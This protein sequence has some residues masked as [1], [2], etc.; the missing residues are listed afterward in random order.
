VA[1]VEYES[2]QHVAHITLNSPHNRN[3]LSPS[4]IA[5]LSTA[6]TRASEN[7]DLKVVLLDAAPPVFCA[8]ID[9]VA[10]DSGDALSLA[11]ALTKVQR[12]LVAHPLPVVAQVAGPVRAG[13]VGLLAPVDVVLASQEANFS[14]GEVRLGLTAGVIAV[15]LQHRMAPRS[16]A[17]MLLG[18]A[19]WTAQ[20]AQAA[21]LVTRCVPPDQLDTEAQRTLAE[22]IQGV[23]SALTQNKALLNSHLLAELDARGAELAELSARSFSSAEAQAAMAAFLNKQS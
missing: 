9:L 23:R 6:L 7:T 4:L 22:I 13:G 16:L 2:A 1:F 12:Q 20:A 5:E 21:G 11:M 14:L 17:E 19:L 3:A 18:G 15:A 8:G 10:A